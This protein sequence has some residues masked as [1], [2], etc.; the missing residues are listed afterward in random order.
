[1]YQF[2]HIKIMFFF[3]TCCLYVISVIVW[4]QFLSPHCTS[5]AV[6]LYTG[7]QVQRLKP[8]AVKICLTAGKS[9]K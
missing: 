3:F 2:Q 1:M 4:Q 5:G 7:V 6:G 8:T 9:L